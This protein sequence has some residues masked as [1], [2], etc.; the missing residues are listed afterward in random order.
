MNKNNH[1]KLLE[2]VINNTINNYQKYN[3]ALFSKLNPS[4]IIKSRQQA[5]VCGILTKSNSDYYGVY[6]GYYVEF[7]VKQTQQTKFYLGQIKAH[8]LTRIKNVEAFGGCAFLIIFFQ[9]ENSY[10]AIQPGFIKKWNKFDTGKSIPI[11]FFQNYGYQLKINQFSQLN[12]IDAIHQFLY[13]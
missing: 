10:Y 5:T 2:S 11:S 12:I 8:Q 4:I 7:E 3:I 6:R 9:T 1:G 13:I